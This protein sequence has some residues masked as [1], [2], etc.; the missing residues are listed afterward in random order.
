M[1]E[2]DDVRLHTLGEHALP[3]D[4]LSVLSVGS[5]AHGWANSRSDHDFYVISATTWRGRRTGSI[6]V[7][8]RP[9]VVPVQVITVGTQRCELKY[10][11]DAQ[12]DE[13]LTKVT[14][15]RFENYRVSE[16]V[17]TEPEELFLERLATSLPLLGTDWLELRREQLATTA[18]RTFLV[19]RSLSEVDDCAEDALGQLD[20]GDVYSAV[21]SARK[22]LGHVVDALLESHGHYGSQVVKW[23]ARRLLEA[24]PAQ[25]SFE[26]YWELETMTGFDPAAPQRW[27]NEVI[28][29][30]KD[31]ALE[32]EA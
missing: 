14:W 17:L 24:A 31:V 28:K 29:V 4:L 13:M 6:S 2:T 30:C 19:T 8:L 26:R 15:R 16:K 22:A 27:V 21:L 32:V 10:W 9:R 20:A 23:R 12:V 5:Y 3:A 11:T 7:P 25:L 18:F 1:I